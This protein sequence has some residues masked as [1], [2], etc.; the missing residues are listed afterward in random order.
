MLRLFW[1]LLCLV[2]TI[3]AFACLQVEGTF[4][5]DGED[6]KIAQKAE[7]GKEYAHP[8]QGFILSF[9]IHP[10]PKSSKAFNLKYK[11]EERTEKSLDMVSMGV[12]EISMGQK[13]QI[14]AKGLEKKP[15]TIL[16]IQL[17]E[18]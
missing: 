12:E 14:Y 15:N 7:L 8:F 18:I 6:L 4:S 3:E 5:V 16:D 17:T 10:D 2:F 9:T 13:R 11:V 1:V